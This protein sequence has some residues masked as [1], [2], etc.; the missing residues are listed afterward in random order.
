MILLWTF[1][2]VEDVPNRP[3]S[4][5]AHL[6]E[7]DGVLVAEDDGMGVPI[8]YWQEG[9][10]V[11]QRHSL[12]VPAEAVEGGYLLQTGAYW[13]DTME[14]WAVCDRDGVPSDQIILTTVS[15]VD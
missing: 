15:V 11:V 2:E 4:L 6:V 3:L 9:D 7:P 10:V 1:W 13:L 14:R 12:K 8:E 5:M